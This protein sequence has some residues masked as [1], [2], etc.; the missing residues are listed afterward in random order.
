MRSVAEC[1]VE[2]NMAG[3]AVNKALT[4]EHIL[5]ARKMCCTKLA[6]AVS[7]WPYYSDV[8]EEVG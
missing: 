2:G 8:G 4:E 1:R 7:I 5:R 3:A 6:F